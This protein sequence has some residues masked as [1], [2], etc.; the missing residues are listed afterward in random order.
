MG[1]TTRCVTALLWCMQAPHGQGRTR[2]GRVT[3]HGR[4][5]RGT[6]HPSPT[7]AAGGCGRAAKPAP[8]GA[9][10]TRVAVCPR[11]HA[12]VACRGVPVL[13]VR[14]V[15]R[16]A[17]RGDRRHSVGVAARCLAEGKGVGGLSCGAQ[18]PGGMRRQSRPLRRAGRAR[19]AR[20]WR[21]RRGGGSRR[22]SCGGVPCNLAPGCG[23]PVRRGGG[24]PRRGGMVWRV[25]V[26]GG[27]R[28]AVARRSP[29][30]EPVPNKGVQATANSVRSSLAPAARRA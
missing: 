26:G 5:D 21:A 4:R 30:P 24:L 1:S 15:A 8:V 28:G 18:G 20:A 29:V 22:E 7:G 17:G 9:A 19:G 14:G 11:A 27:Q 2:A 23:V 10:Q 3:R 6:G 25:V 13:H 12:R 16:R